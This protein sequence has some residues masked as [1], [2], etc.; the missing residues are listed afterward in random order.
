M[1]DSIIQRRHLIM[2]I[3]G[4]IYLALTGVAPYDRLTWFMEI[5][6]ILIGLPILIISYKKFPLTKIAYTLIFIHAIILMHGGE[7]TYARAPLGYW[8]QDM[9]SMDRNPYDRIGHFAQ[10]F[11]PAIIAR[12]IL[13]RRSPLQVGKW[14]SFIVVC[15]CLAF[16]AFYEMI[17]WWAA[18]SLEQSAEAFLGTQ[19]DP[20]DTQWDMFLA[21][22]G[23][24]TALLI[25]S[26]VHDEQLDR[27][28]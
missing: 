10:G 25:L 14:L 27:L 18:I 22:C 21:L 6:P 2:L 11:G 17:E 20:W 15:F 23:A 13:L 9:F 28:S 5:V 1:N 26:R 8:F 12:E 24:C 16:S 7:H 4:L 19:G 3:I